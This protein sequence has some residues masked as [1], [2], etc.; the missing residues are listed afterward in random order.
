MGGGGGGDTT[1]VQTS[2][3]WSGIKPYLKEGYENLAGAAGEIAPY[4]PGQTYAGFAP[5]QEQGQQ[6]M[7]NYAQAIQPYQTNAMNAMDWGMNAVMDPASNQALQGHIQSAIRPLTEQ[8]TEQVLPGIRRQAEMYG[9]AGNRTGLA[10]GVASRSYMDAVGDISSGMMSEAYGQGL[11]QQA[12]MAALYPGIAQAGTMPGQ[13]M[14]QVGAQQQAMDQL[15]IDEAMSRH[16][17][18]YN[19]PYERYTN[20][21]NTL[22]GTPWG[23]TT[24]TGADPNAQSTMSQLAGSGL[25]G[26]GTWGA[27]AANPATAGVAVPMGLLAGGLGLFS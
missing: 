15:G 3:P 22:Q 8:Y 13:W 10:E 16:Y 14:Q 21:L 12:R 20:Y 9:G 5:L 26:I 27:L 18:D 2:E 19:A 11:Q 1:Q 7:A 23:S 24:T 6:Y 4:Y 25:M 17:Y